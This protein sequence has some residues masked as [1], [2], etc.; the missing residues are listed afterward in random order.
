MPHDIY[1]LR[2]FVTLTESGSLAE[3][4][5][6]LDVTP[7][8]VSQRL[9]QLESRL[10]VQLAHRSTRRF[11]LTEE[12]K[13]LHAGAGDLLQGLEGL[14]DSLRA[15]SERVTG[16]LHVCGP[17]GFGRRY[18]AQAVSA[19]HEQH[20]ALT[21]SLTLSDVV[22]AADTNRYDLIVHIGQLADS[23]VVAF[24]IA[25]N[26]RFICASPHYLAERPAPREPKE[27][28][29]HRC[30]AL[31]ENDEDVTLWRLRK[32]RSETAVRVRAELSSNDGDVVK[33]WALAGKGLVLRSEW[34]VAGN[35]ER[36]ELVRVLADWTAPHADVVALTARRAGLSA[37]A[38]LF[39]GF[40]QDRFQP[41]PPWRQM[42]PIAAAKNKKRAPVLSA[43]SPSCPP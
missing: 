19:F 18:L 25:P 2:F 38:R 17:L 5:R 10:G 1:D 20:P 7:S 39:L 22:A 35:L 42:P 12:G 21:V 9:Q 23:S 29:G 3:A 15:R 16:T 27:L 28:A 26:Q 32:K 33:Q 31:R 36:G 14:I 6:R 40:L 4:A 8:A 37:R 11:S 34:D 43:D 30:I 24:P 41:A 13:L